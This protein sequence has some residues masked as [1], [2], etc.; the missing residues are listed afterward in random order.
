M[1]ELTLIS[2]SQ[3]PIQ[4]L[5]EGALPNELRLLEAGI[6][7]SEQRLQEFE[8]RYGLSTIDFIQRYENDELEETL[9]FAEWIGEYRLRERL[10][11]KAEALRAIQISHG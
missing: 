4:P 5:V 10:L 9:E 2:P 11:E 7:R 3:R 8:T 6:R 1:A